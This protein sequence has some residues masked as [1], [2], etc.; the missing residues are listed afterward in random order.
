MAG[1]MLRAI[2]DLYGRTNPSRGG[3]K[4]GGRGPR[5]RDD[6]LPMLC[7]RTA[8]RLRCPAVR[9]VASQRRIDV[10]WTHLVQTVANPLRYR[11]A[12]PTRI[13]RQ[14][15]RANARAGLT[16]TPSHK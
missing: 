8:R 11:Q 7:L 16:Q 9:G 1:R 10:D 3:P 4:R 14:F 13:D 12:V 5:G 15:R 2:G 6:Q